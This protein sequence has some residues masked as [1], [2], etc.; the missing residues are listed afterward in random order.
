MAYLEAP[1]CIADWRASETPSQ[2]V[3]PSEVR[4]DNCPIGLRT[5]S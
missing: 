5:V 1:V 4:D 3:E 2:G